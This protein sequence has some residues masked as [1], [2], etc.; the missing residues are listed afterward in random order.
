ME[1]P[2]MKNLKLFTPTFCIFYFLW[3]KIL[4]FH[5]HK[6]FI[7]SKQQTFSGKSS[8]SD[9]CNSFVTNDL[10]IKFSPKYLFRNSP[11]SVIG[12]KSS[13]RRIL[14]LKIKRKTDDNLINQTVIPT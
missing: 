2:E 12:W 13:F 8:F 3:F 9:T 14:P 10:F 5:N 7:Y 11:P 6:S 1:D 4:N